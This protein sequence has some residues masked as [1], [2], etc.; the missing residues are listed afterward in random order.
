VAEC[1]GA[2]GRAGFLFVRQR[3]RTTLQRDSQFADVVDRVTA[4]TAL[5]PLK[6]HTPDSF[7]QALRRRVDAYFAGSGRK[8]RDCPRMYVKSAVILGGCVALYVLLVVAAGA[9][10]VAIPLAALLGLALASAAFN[11][12][13]DGGH[14][15]YSDHRWINNLASL[16]LDLLGGSSY[17]WARKHNAIHHSYTNVT[18]HDDDINV[19]FLGRLSPHQKRLK[20]HR[21]QHLYLWVLYGFLPIKWHLYDDFRD[22]LTG[23]IGGHRLPRPRGR[24]LV[25]FIGGKALFFSLAF[26]IPMLLHPW[27]CVLALYGIASFVQGVALSVVFQMAHCVEEAAFPQPPDTG[28]IESSWAV[29]Q[30]E[31]TVDF[32]PRNRVLAWFVGGLNFQIEHHLFPQICHVHYPALATLVEETCRE[33]GLR[34][35]AYKTFLAGLASHYRWLRRMGEPVAA[36]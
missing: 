2:F 5:A 3:V 19:G 11:I 16:T 34:Y 1:L 20:F 36:R 33:F 26:G 12:Q 4:D 15:A 22:V 24:D 6:F 9:W 18:G 27:W 25:S 31:T 21:L 23:R 32:A 13:H 35:K 30:V 17:V 28:R 10:W 29:H 7:R 8:P 14:G